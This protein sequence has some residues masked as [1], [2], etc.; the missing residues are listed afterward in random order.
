M[1]IEALIMFFKWCTIING[2][3]LA[4]WAA[5]VIFCPNIVYNVEKKFFP[6]PRDFFDKFI[7]AFLAMFKIL[8][9]IF[10]LVPLIALLI[11]RAT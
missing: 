8:F 6:V 3:L 10:N 4:F 5:L 1:N 11:M 2:L 7:Y 9:L